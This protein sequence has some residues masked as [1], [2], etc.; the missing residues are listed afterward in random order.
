MNKKNG[1]GLTPFP[2]ARTQLF[3]T[4]VVVPVSRSRTKI[5]L[6]P[7]VSPVTRLVAAD[8]NATYRQSDEKEETDES[9]SPINPVQL[10]ETRYVVLV[11]RSRTKI[12]V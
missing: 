12:S 4:S 5:S 10:F 7:L 11:W 8:S 3:E 2:P 6:I 1:F 9:P